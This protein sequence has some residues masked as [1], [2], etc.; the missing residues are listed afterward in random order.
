MALHEI[1][2]LRVSS[3]KYYVNTYTSFTRT[4]LDRIGCLYSRCAWY[5]DTLKQCAVMALAGLLSLASEED[6]M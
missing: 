6:T 2:P 3:V 5:D 1:C 4:E